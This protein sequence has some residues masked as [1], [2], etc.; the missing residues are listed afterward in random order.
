MV[1]PPPETFTVPPGLAPAFAGR[2]VSVGHAGMRFLAEVEGNPIA[3]EALAKD[4]A[5]PVG[6]VLLMRHFERSET[7]D[8]GAPAPGPVLLMEKTT[9]KGSSESTWVYTAY[10]SKA[11]RVPAD[12]MERCGFCHKDAPKDGFFKPKLGN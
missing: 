12:Q 7:S 3:K 4:T 8:G 10:D 9:T 1:A 5:F 11:R 2:F 6:A